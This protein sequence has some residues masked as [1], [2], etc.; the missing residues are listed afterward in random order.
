MKKI[1]LG[2]AV[3]AFISTGFVACKGKKEEAKTEQTNEG[4][5]D[6]KTDGKMDGAGTDGKMEST[7]NSGDITVPNFS[8]P[9]VTKW[10]QDYKNFLDAYVTAIKDKDYTKISSLAQEFSTNWASKSMEVGMK[11]SQS[12][13]ESKKFTDF[14]Q[15]ISAKFTEAM[16]SAMPKMQ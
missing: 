15:A 12:P 6:G 10:C 11:V 1:F 13:E 2:F 3:L 5:M 16:K 8:D 9:A 7:S 14:T 4:K